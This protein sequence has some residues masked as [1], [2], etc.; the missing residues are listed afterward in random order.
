MER[1]RQRPP[2][3]EKP[4]KLPYIAIQFCNQILPNGNLHQPFFQEQRWSQHL[5]PPWRERLFLT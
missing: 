2:C 4:I 3:P 5:P 1:L